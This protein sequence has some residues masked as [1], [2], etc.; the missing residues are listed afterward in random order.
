MPCF[1]VKVWV[2]GGCTLAEEGRGRAGGRTPYTLLQSSLSP[3]AAQA[4][5]LAVMSHSTPEGGGAGLGHRVSEDKVFL[6]ELTFISRLP[7]GPQT[8]GSSCHISTHGD[9]LVLVEKEG[10][11]PRSFGSSQSPEDNIS[12]I[13]KGSI[14]FRAGDRLWEPGSLGLNPSSASCQPCDLGQIT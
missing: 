10:G 11:K 4:A 8:T 2:L 9:F 7:M 5:H 14:K 6:E 1:F 3:A 13:V 12:H